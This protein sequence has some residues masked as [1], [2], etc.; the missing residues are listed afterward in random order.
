[1]DRRYLMNVQLHYYHGPLELVLSLLSLG[2]FVAFSWL[3]REMRVAFALHGD[4]CRIWPGCM[5]QAALDRSSDLN[6]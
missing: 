5:M 3:F 4:S 1:M 2:S 6:I